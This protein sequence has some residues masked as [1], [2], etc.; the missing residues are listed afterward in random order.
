MK[1][2]LTE[3]AVIAGLAAGCGNPE[4]TNT[5]PVTPAAQMP[6]QCP[7]LSRPTD[8][9]DGACVENGKTLADLIRECAGRIKTVTFLTGD[10]RRPEQRLLKCEEKPQPLTSPKE[11]AGQTTPD[12]KKQPEQKP[13]KL[14]KNPQ[15]EHKTTKK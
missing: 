6:D 2:G 4:T 12:D 3:I 5:V 13:S 1:L 8:N 11:S 9:K 10:E 14:G 15:P 7:F